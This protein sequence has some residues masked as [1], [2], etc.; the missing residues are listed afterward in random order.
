MY[1]QAVFPGAAYIEMAW[2]AEEAFGWES[3]ELEEIGLEEVLV[4]EEEEARTIQLILTPESA[5]TATFRVFSSGPEDEKWRLHATGRVRIGERDETAAPVSLDDARSRCREEI[6]AKDFYETLRQRGVEYGSSFQSLESL[7]W[8]K[9][10]AVGRIR[11]PETLAEEEASYPLHPV[12]LDAGFQLL[13]A[14]WSG[15][16]AQAEEDK[17]YMPTDLERLR[18]DAETGMRLWGHSRILSGDGR[19][20]MG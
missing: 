20:V 8:S 13:G 10:E 7:W 6:A 17:V 16:G 2:P 5:G 4:L 18:V 19:P 3:P 15:D 12:L 9:G 11:L 1:G 14:A